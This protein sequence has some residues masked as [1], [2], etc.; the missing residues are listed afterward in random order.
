MKA[1]TDIERRIAPIIV[2]YVLMLT[3]CLANTM[4]TSTGNNL[5]TSRN[6]TVEKGEVA[7]ITAVV[8]SADFPIAVWTQAGWIIAN[9]IGANDA[10]PQDCQ[11]HVREGILGQFYAACPGL[12]Q[13]FIPRDGADFI[14]I[15]LMLGR[16]SPD[17]IPVTV[18]EDPSVGGR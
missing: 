3:G 1:D 4:T 9:P 13:L 6:F 5:S 15:I 8:T 17:K 16:N 7:Y 11:L 2:L 10:V 12:S 18:T 14:D